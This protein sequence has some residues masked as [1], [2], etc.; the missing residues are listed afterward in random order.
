MWPFR[1]KEP[2]RGSP[3]VAAG[4]IQRVLSILTPEEAKSLG[5]LPAE[6][7]V[8]ILQ[9]EELTVEALRPNPRFVEF[10]HRVIRIAAPEDPELQTA[11]AEQGDGWVYIIDLRTPE[12][13]Q[14][15]VPPDDIIGAFEVRS[16]QIVAGSYWPNENY[17]AF[18]RN[19]VVQLPP[20]LREAFIRALPRVR[21][22]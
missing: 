17:R 5:G 10:M 11:A 1:R 13:A 14:G 7:I 8:G 15:R 4:N 16:G 21:D 12:G 18:T 20:S 19:G 3:E 22:A 6:A 2:T 9:G